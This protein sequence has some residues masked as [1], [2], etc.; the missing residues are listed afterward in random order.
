MDT[1]NVID[2]K[3]SQ[4]NSEIKKAN[5]DIGKIERRTEKECNHVAKTLIKGKKNRK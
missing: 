5:K 2:A 3:L 4:L 1:L